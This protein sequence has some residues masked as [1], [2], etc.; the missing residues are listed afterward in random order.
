MAKRALVIG[1]ASSGSGKT[2]FSIGLMKALM[3]KKISVQPFKVGP[4]YIDPMFH[5]HVTGKASYNLPAWMV[6]DE[7]LKYLFHK[8]LGEDD[9]A[10]VEGVMG[11]Y[12]GHQTDGFEGS[13]AYIAEALNIPAII[14]FNA[15]SMSLSAAAIV[16]GFSEFKEN[17]MIKGVV[18][19]NVASEMHYHM[20][21]KGI[22]TFT[23]VKCYGYLKKNS[24]IVIG[25]RHLGLLQAEEIDNLDAKIDLISEQIEE[26]VDLD[27]ILCDFVYGDIPIEKE[28]I[29]SF[30]K[31]IDDLKDKVTAMGGLKVGIASDASFSFYY[32]ENLKTL[33]EIGVELI[34]FSPL[35]DQFLP[36]GC[37]GLYIGGGYPEIYAPHLSENTSLLQD[38]KKALDDGMPC[39][40]ECGGLMYLTEDITY[41]DGTYNMVGF[42]N[43]HSRMTQKLQRFGH[44]N[45]HVTSLGGL[46]HEPIDF[47]AHEFHK[48]VIDGEN[49][50]AMCYQITKR[51][52]SWTCGYTS[53]NV[54]G[55]YAHN[56]FYSNIA[57]LSLLLELWGI[58]RRDNI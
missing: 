47:R 57:F 20:L 55:T 29:I 14:I 28:T 38:I 44:V 1:G 40:A 56:H 52:T 41:N 39:Y 17:S 53:N 31:Q 9:F 51:K 6:P 26:T 7:A 15:G 54:V 32:D 45:V 23:D 50:S 12:D 48:S 36:K 37:Q 3:N 43:G 25:S 10:I 42:F 16:K 46:K 35:K 27:G 13:T 5:R 33:E 34:P 21:K 49:I 22:E 4:D 8:R 19:N 58:Y 11:Y 2:T 18:L 24:D 30:D